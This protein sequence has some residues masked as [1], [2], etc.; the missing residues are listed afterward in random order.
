MDRAGVG[1]E[2]PALNGFGAYQTQTANKAFNTEKKGGYTES[3][4]KNLWHFARYLDK[5]PRVAPKILSAPCTLPFLR[6]ESL[7]CL[8]SPEQTNQ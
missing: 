8:Q 4:E 1:V 7:T 5:V 6:V 3:A 2:V